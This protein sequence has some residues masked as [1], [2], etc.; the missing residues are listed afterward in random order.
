MKA[1]GRFELPPEQRDALHRARRL[2]WLTVLAV[3][4]AVT[5]VGLVMQ[6]SQAM[7][8]AWFEDI[9]SFVPPIAFLVSQ[10]FAQ[11]A[12]NRTFPYGYQRATS[13]AFLAGSVALTLFGLF[14]LGDSA[15]TLIKREHAS[16]G[17]TVLFGYE[18]WAGWLMIGAM[19]VSTLP[20]V[21]LGRLKLVH[22]HTLHDKT[23]AADAD[24]NKAD[25][26][27][28]I[29]TIAGIVGIGLG[30]WWADGVAAALVSIDIVGDGIKNLR[31][32]VADLC[33]RAPRTID[34]DPA[35]T[36]DRIRLALLHLPWVVDADVR[37]REEGHVLCGEAFIT[38]L[39]DGDPLARLEQA[40][41]IAKDASWNVRD[42]V[43]TLARPSEL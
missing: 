11:R 16:I 31:R 26:L 17:L 27:T 15:M 28:G 32:V 1:R 14:I 4:F 38:M 20:L 12:P 40:A 24:M 25:W 41:K 23:L 42:M 39:D 36:P 34:G 21:I 29:A 10:R 7:K 2:E 18:L 37:M 19:I 9:L 3:A 5:V 6:T 8:A 30:W 43:I 22:A 13:I 33:D 35:D